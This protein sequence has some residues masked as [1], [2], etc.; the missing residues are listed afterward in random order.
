MPLEPSWLAEGGQSGRGTRRD[1]PARERAG[2]M[3]AA[4][5]EKLAGELGE[6]LP[7]CLDE[8]DDLELSDLAAALSTARVRQAEDVE[9]AIDKAMRYVP[10]GFRGA[11]RKVLIG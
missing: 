5:R 9:A 2:R 3:N 4:A 1:A 8:L 10:W 11:V 6:P 7:A